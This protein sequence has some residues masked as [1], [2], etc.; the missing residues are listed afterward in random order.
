MPTDDQMER[1]LVLL[2]AHKKKVAPKQSRKKLV[3]EELRDEDIPAKQKKP[4][5]KERDA[6]KE[7]MIKQKM[8]EYLKPPPKK[9]SQPAPPPEPAP[10][11]DE[12]H[13]SA[14]D[15]EQLLEEESIPAPQVSAP[16]T[17]EVHS[18]TQVINEIQQNIQ[19]EIDTFKLNQISSFIK[20]Y[21]N[22]HI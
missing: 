15:L 22:R 11:S 4:T 9:K 1:L 21:K 8:E 20:S 18:I 16:K 10:T 6:E 12:V 2:E 19:P 5:K 13:V 7:Q 3:V 14:S 17:Q